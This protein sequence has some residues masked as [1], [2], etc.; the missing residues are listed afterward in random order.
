MFGGGLRKYSSV[1]NSFPF[2]GVLF[3]LG[4]GRPSMD[5]G[6]LRR[7][8]FTAVFLKAPASKVKVLYSKVKT[9]SCLLKAKRTILI[10]C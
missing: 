6:H 4:G 3:L 9:H 8:I 1:G 7:K 10:Y 2:G 5:A